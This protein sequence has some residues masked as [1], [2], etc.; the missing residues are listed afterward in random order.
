MAGKKSPKTIAKDKKPLLDLEP[1]ELPEGFPEDFAQVLEKIPD[2]KSRQEIIR[3]VASTTRI[4][5]GPLPPPE[6]LKGY[7]DI[8]PG[9]A[10]EIFDMAKSQQN[11]RQQTE[12]GIIEH[13]KKQENWTRIIGT[14]IIFSIIA[15]GILAMAWEQTSVAVTV[16]GGCIAS[17]TI[18]FL[19]GARNNKSKK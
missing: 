3:I 8:L 1:V 16:F 9:A 18:A 5:Q 14:L 4:H 15:C 2:P 13:S 10:R 7:E 17:I 6:D 11:Y 12:S 19:T